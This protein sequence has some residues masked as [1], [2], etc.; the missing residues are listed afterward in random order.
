MREFGIQ[1]RIVWIR[2]VSLSASLFP[3]LKL[4]FYTERL[5]LLN[6]LIRVQNQGCKDGNFNLE[7]LRKSIKEMKKDEEHWK[8][9]CVAMLE[10]LFSV[11]EKEM[12]YEKG[13][14]GESHSCRWHSCCS[15]NTRQMEML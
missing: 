6:H 8:P 12:D 1:S 14:I 10:E 7:I 15:A 11:R 13:W 4:T 2:M 5:K 9:G 3:M